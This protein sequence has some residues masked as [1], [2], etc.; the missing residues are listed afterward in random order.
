MHWMN[1]G[2]DGPQHAKKGMRLKSQRVDKCR[3]VGPFGFGLRIKFKSC[4]VEP[5]LSL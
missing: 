4:K 3:K 2:L 1:V 5:D